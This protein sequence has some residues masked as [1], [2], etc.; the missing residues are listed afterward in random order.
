M[1]KQ[2]YS[3]LSEKI[4]KQF[5]SLNFF[6]IIEFLVVIC[7]MAMLAAI[8]MPALRKARE[9]ARESQCINNRH[10]YELAERMYEDAY[11]G[12]PSESLDLLTSGKFL[13]TGDLMECPSGGVYLWIGE[14]GKDIAPEMGCS[15]HHYAETSDEGNGDSGDE[16]SVENGG[17]SGDGGGKGKGNDDEK[18][19]G[20]GDGNGKGKGDGNGKGNG[21]E[22]GGKDENG[23]RDGGNSGGWW[24]AV[25]PLT[26]LLFALFAVVAL[27]NIPLKDEERA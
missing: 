22:D 20:N 11:D 4:S 13:N 24:G 21:Q 25:D 3:L 17:G 19:S 7:I 10:Q 2:K 12:E 1:K 9:Q 15:I 26:G 14:R 8:G 6:T 27:C 5:Y 23:N 16:D 18:G